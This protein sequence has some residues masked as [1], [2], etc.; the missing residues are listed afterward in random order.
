[1][2]AQLVTITE[3]LCHPNADNLELAVTSLGHKCITK[4]GA[5]K[6]GDLATWLAPDAVVDITRPEFSFLKKGRIGVM[7]LR[8]ERSFGL[9]M[10]PAEDPV[11][12]YAVGHYEPPMRGGDTGTRGEPSLPAPD[13]DLAHY[14]LEVPHYYHK[15]APEL[16]FPVVFLEK[17]HGSLARI[18]F[19][20]GGGIELASKNRWV[21]PLGTNAWARGLQKFAA[22]RDGADFLSRAPRN[23]LLLAELLNVQKGFNYGCAPGEVDIMPFALVFSDGEV[24]LNPNLI[25]GR[26]ESGTG[27]DIVKMG[28]SLQSGP[29]AS[30]GKHIREGVVAWGANGKCIKFVSPEYYEAIGGEV[31]DAA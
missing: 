15:H 27:E 31:A 20:K 29:T 18:A 1:M 19:T 4:K 10:P 8:G 30:Y 14:R 5:F 9:L 2:D 3:I 7:K 13:M 6:P 17:I 16:T 11:S 28:L 12:F 23:S 24:E 21:D 25:L 22:N 26:L